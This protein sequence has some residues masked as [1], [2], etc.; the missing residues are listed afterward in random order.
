MTSSQTRVRDP[1]ELDVDLAVS[2]LVWDYLPTESQRARLELS[3]QAQHII[4]ST[5]DPRADT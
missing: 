1:V 5:V 4:I 2:E 3:F